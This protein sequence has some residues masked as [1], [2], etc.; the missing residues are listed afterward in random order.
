MRACDKGASPLFE[1]VRLLYNLLLLAALPWVCARLVWKSRRE[2]GYRDRISERF[3]AAPCTL[4]TGCVW[5]HAVSA[6]E[7]NAAAPMIR[8]LRERFPTRPFLVTTMTPAGSMRVTALLGDVARHCYAP[9][10]YPWAVRR[11]LRRVRP[12]ALVLM[13]TELWPNVVRQ[14]AASGA[15]VYLVN[16]RLS[17]RS[18]QGYRRI[19]SLVRPMLE[20]LRCVVCQYEDT[21]DRFRALGATAVEV[22]GSVKFDAELPPDDFGVGGLSFNGAPVW[23]AGSTHAGEEEIVVE[24]HRRLRHSYPDLRLILAPRHTARVPTVLGLLRSKGVT[25]SLLSAREPDAS[26]LVADVMGT[27][28]HLYGLA[29]VAFVG[30]SLDRTGGHNPIEA[31][32]H[33]VP[34]L[35]GPARFKIE[36]IWGRFEAAGCAHGV[37]DVADIVTEV[38][39][40]LNDPARCEREGKSAQAVIAANRG[41]RGALVGR[42]ADWL[43]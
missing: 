17:A 22:T 33:G 21:A 27:L 5:F 26:V 6:G 37:A 43:A 13:E 2:P 7:V 20:R 29:D 19:G 23:I 42:L 41:A 15:D 25:A 9:Y 10:D 14:T 39:A 24:A 34:L 31:A 1:M 36:E 32:W 40:L 3:G 12:S 11:F 28:P 4:P 16:A 8:A 30:G 38:G 35:M 18:F